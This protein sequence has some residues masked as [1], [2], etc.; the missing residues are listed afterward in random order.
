MGNYFLKNRQYVEDSYHILSN[1]GVNFMPGIGTYFVNT[2]DKKLVIRRPDMCYGQA[3][4][5]EMETDGEHLNWL[6]FNPRPMEGG[7]GRVI[8]RNTPD[9]DIIYSLASQNW[10]MLNRPFF[11]EIHEI[12]CG[13]YVITRDGD[14]LNSGSRRKIGEW[15]ACFNH[16]DLEKF[17]GNIYCSGYNIDA[18]PRDV[19]GCDIIT[20]TPMDRKTD[21]CIAYATTAIRYAGILM[22]WKNYGVD[23]SVNEEYLMRAMLY[24]AINSKKVNEKRKYLDEI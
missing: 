5:Y 15:S 9:E 7:T 2:R 18:Q 11:S 19:L 4:K 8:L 3:I 10:K 16:D 24:R 17:M 6:R 1:C 22:L 14:V 21:G 13:P 23:D 12:F 20:D